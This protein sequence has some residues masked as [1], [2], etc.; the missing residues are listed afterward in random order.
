MSRNEVLAEYTGCGW[1]YPEYENMADE[2]VRLR[3]ILS[4]LR[5]PS[6]KILL[7]AVEAVPYGASYAA[8]TRCIPAA[9]VAAEREVSNDAR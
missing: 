4:A 8:L 7:A 2:I 5:E 6:E 1:D 3:A 9:V